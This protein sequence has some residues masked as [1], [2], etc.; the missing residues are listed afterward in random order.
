VEKFTCMTKM[1]PMCEKISHMKH[2]VHVHGQISHAGQNCFTWKKI[3]MHRKK[4]FY[5]CETFHIHYKIVS[6]MWKK[7]TW[8]KEFHIQGKIVKKFHMYR[9]GLRIIFTCTLNISHACE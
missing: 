5:M 1:F 3:Q 7:F 8:A 2:E 9:K 6:Y 4:L